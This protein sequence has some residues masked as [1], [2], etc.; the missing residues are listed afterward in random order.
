M[1]RKKRTALYLSG[2]LALAVGLA[3]CTK[4]PETSS[5]NAPPG[6]GKSGG[7]LSKVTESSG[8]VTVPAGTAISVVLDQSISSK[9]ARSGDRF[10]ATVIE[11]VVVGGRTI[12]P[13]DARA[14]GRVI[15]AR[16][17]GRLQTVARLGL[18]L[19]SVEVGGKSYEIETSSIVRSGSS[20]KTR[21]VEIIGGG[22]ALGA[23][24]GG[25]A[26]GGKGAAIG[27]AA[28]AGAGTAG[29]AATGKKDITLPAEATLTFRLTRPVSIQARG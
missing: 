20:H 24:V 8:P 21:N 3:G 13:R 7:L 28:G 29:A 5:E 15:E 4:A 10:D 18:T 6:A 16:E 22:T 1:K 23:I 19:D 12:I 17:S 27:A 26:G 2:L 25:L 11:P 9:D 14:K